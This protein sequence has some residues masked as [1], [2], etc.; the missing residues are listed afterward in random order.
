MPGGA[1]SASAPEPHTTTSNPPSFASDRLDQRF[2]LDA[3][4]FQRGHGHGL[5]C[6]WKPA[7]PK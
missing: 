6:D 5:A 1:C 3:E 2:V 7:A 4:D